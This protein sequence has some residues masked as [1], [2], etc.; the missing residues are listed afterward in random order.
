MHTIL[1]F[2]LLAA[3]SLTDAA[4]TVYLIRHGEKP[5]NRGNGLS[6]TGLGRAQC[7][8]NVFGP[9]SGYDIGYIMAQTP[10][11]STCAHFDERRWILLHLFERIDMANRRSLTK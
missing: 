4:A 8:K 10:K 2:F 1:P 9:N 11:S 3:A 7:L 5:S 6:T